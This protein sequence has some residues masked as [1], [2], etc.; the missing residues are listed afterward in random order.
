M[1]VV[2]SD[3]HF[4]DGTATTEDVPARAFELFVDHVLDLAEHAGA[5]R[6]TF[7]FLGD[8][9]DLLRTEHWFAPAPRPPTGPGQR[10]RL[11]GAVPPPAT[12]G[13]PDPFGVEHRPWGARS[14][15][16]AC[17]QRA[18]EIATKVAWNCRSQLRVLARWDSRPGVIRDEKIRQGVQARLARLRAR[19]VADG[20][21]AFEIERL[22]LPGNHDRLARI[23]PR[24]LRVVTRCLRATAAPE[25]EPGSVRF[26][27][28]G[29]L[30]RHGHEAEALNFE[31]VDFGHRLPTVGDLRNVPIGDLVATECLARL[32]YGVRMALLA[33]GAPPEV[34]DSVH[35]ALRVV[36]DVR[37]LS[38]VVRW[39]AHAG[40][41]ADWGHDDWNAVIREIV[42]REAK[43]LL[44][45]MMALPFSRRWARRRLLRAPGPVLYLWVARILSALLTLDQFA[46]V[47][48]FVDRRVGLGT[49]DDSY[50]DA[51]MRRLGGGAPRVVFGHTHAFRHVPLRAA[52]GAPEQVYFNS[53]TWRHRVHEAL[54]RSGFVSAKDMTYL[55][56][57]ADDENRGGSGPGTTY[58]AWNGVMKKRG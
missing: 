38:A 23:D 3:L 41:T 22:F 52:R 6:L 54:D 21:P 29:V 20:H 30:A 40:R 55:V 47:L 28:E 16:A 25:A 31:P 36:E 35:E 57:Y 43:R 24:I 5:R 33:R 4:G 12:A 7:L 18:L 2:I 34:A 48:G 51:A 27:A 45:R 1:L 32:A 26:P 8:I 37:P 39:V 42:Q 58:E 15:S 17:L 10:A 56:F 13:A 46:W 14:P 19:A 11:L 44:P 53:G 49:G 9:F 50:A